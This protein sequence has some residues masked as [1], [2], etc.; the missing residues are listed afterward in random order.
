MAIYKIENEK[1]TKLSDTTFE[2][3]NIYEVKNLQKYLSNSIDI[4]DKDLL[5]IATE[6]SDWEESRRS[7]DI[8]CVDTDG[9]LVV[10]EIKRTQD[11]GHMD[12]QSLRYA[13]MI[14]KMKF[15]KAVSTYKSYLQKINHN[16]DAE[17][18]MLKFLGWSEVIEDDF[19]QDV[20]IILVSA[21]FSI[22]LTTSILWLNERDL[23]I[24]C[25]KVNLQKDDGKIFF[26]IQQVIPLPEA[27]DYQ[28]RLK[29]KAIE[30]RL[31]RRESSREQS[32]ISKLFD[33]N[34]LHVGQKVIL[35]PA[36]E[37]GIDKILITAEISRVGR[38]CLNVNGSTK[39]Y[40]FSSLR[41][42]LTKKYNLKD[43]KPDWGYTLKND[44]IEE[45]GKTLAE[46]EKE[47]Y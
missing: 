9:N 23:D 36:L 22:E 46:L 41:S 2:N 20:R 42:Y 32:I 19:A 14:S 34:K 8:L 25:V 27:T 4:I 6:F 15:E 39:I 28:V 37:Q 21:N 7:I 44:W 29:E 43:V 18:A 24:R 12:L 45:N 3:E 10:V 38:K 33:S 47:N 30:E 11:G 16:L 5:V 1:F 35:K 31:V 26:D 13:S 17:Q 40:S